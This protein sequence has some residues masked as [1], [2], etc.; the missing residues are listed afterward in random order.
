MK[1]PDEK[2][3][4]LINPFTLLFSQPRNINYSLQISIGTLQYLKE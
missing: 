2:F 4:K 3:W 1:R